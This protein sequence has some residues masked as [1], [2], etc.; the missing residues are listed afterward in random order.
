MQQQGIPTR[1]KGVNFRS[2]LEA[3]WAHV[4]DL[5]GWDWLYEPIDLEGWVPD[6]LIRCRGK[7]DLLIDIKPISNYGQGR[8]P[9][10]IFAKIEKAVAPV[11]DQYFSAVLGTEPGRGEFRPIGW[12]RNSSW[13]VAVFCASFDDY[14]GSRILTDRVG[15]RQDNLSYE[16]V[17]SGQH[18]KGYLYN[19]HTK[20]VDDAFREA[21]N[22]VQWNA[23]KPKHIADVLASIQI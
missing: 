23:K 3:K 12:L 20:S 22:R 2:R 14:E 19:E 6:F 21:L 8:E 16:D 18:S 11:D 4:F 5:L 10:D 7:R 9:L 1:F 15:L 17:I 13:D